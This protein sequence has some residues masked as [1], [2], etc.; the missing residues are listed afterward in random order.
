MKETDFRT[1]VQMLG[2]IVI[3]KAK[4]DGLNLEQGDLVTVRI[5][6]V[7]KVK[8]VKPNTHPKP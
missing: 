4:R 5:L 7:E 3:P 2:R 1:K 6:K 8:Y